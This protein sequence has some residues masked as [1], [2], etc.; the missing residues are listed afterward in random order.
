MNMSTQALWIDSISLN[1][2][3]VKQSLNVDELDIKVKAAGLNF[4]HS[5]AARVRATSK[6]AGCL[7]TAVGVKV[8]GFQ[9]ITLST[10]AAALFATS[11]AEPQ[12]A[13]SM[14]KSEVD[15]LRTK[16]STS[17]GCAVW[18]LRPQGRPVDKQYE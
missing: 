3:A 1:D 6:Q 2:A 9:R 17:F 14:S 12:A 16:G 13:N 15:G 10:V 11:S 8:T 4:T 7:F 18:Q 5:M